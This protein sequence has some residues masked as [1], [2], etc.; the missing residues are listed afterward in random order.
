MKDEI[1]TYWEMCSRQGMA[2]QRG[3][4]F[5]APPVHGV[6]LMSRRRNAPYVDELSPDESAL[7]YEGHDVPRT[8]DIPDTKIL[9]QPRLDRYGKPHLRTD[10]S[11]R[12]LMNSNKG[13]VSP[14]N[15]PRIRKDAARRLDGSRPIPTE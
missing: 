9:D 11:L 10:V 8:K 15:L 1:L 6:I 12:G 3:M 4:C 7:F 13:N 2:L 14:G 5:R